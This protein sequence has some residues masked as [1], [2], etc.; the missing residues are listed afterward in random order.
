LHQSINHI[1]LFNSLLFLVFFTAV[2]ILYWALPGKF[3]WI[4]LIAASFFFYGVF[5]PEYTV[6]LAVSVLMNYGFGLWIGNTGE[7]KQRRRLLVW[8]I[9]LNVAM[10][11]AF[12]YANSLLPHLTSREGPGG[13]IMPLGISFFTFTNLSYLIEVKR[14]RWKPERHLGYFTVFVTFFPKLI[15]GPIERP[16]TFM[17]QVR[18]ARVFDYDR[19]VSGLRLM[20]WGFFKK[21]V[22][23]DRLGVA[24]DAVYGHPQNQSGFVILIATVFYAVQIYADFSGY[25][26]IARGAAKL[27]GFELSRNFNIPYAAKSIKDFWTRW[28]ITLSNWLRDYIFLPLAFSISRRLKRDHYLGIRTDQ[29]IYSIAISITFV[30]CG[31]WHG[32]GWTFLLW[33]MLYALYLVIGHLSEKPKKRLYRKTGFSNIKWLYNTFQVIVTFTLVTAAWSLFR[34]KDL[35]DFSE[36]VI[37]TSTGWEE[38]IQHPASCIQHLVSPGFTFTDLAIILFTAPLMFLVES[39]FFIVSIWGWCSRQH[40]LV[41]WVLYYGILF[42]IF[43]LGKFENAGFIYFQF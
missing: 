28:H 20:L 29:I 14:R 22:I 42:L 7:N 12:K 3:R 36:I 6:I 24:V 30:L 13:W 9:I 4:L 19:A 40:F 38:V 8:G 15:Q 27:L 26:D 43:L 11:A 10:L 39:P 1:M 16:Q 2:A 37:A 21:L 35:H 18:E 17:T 5:I 23:A 25:I 32:V 33:G 34:A 31:I 41:R